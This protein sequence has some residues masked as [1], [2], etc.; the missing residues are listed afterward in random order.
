MNKNTVLLTVFSVVMLALIVL[1]S[2]LVVN[3][4]HYNLFLLVFA[5]ALACMAGAGLHLG[6]LLGIVSS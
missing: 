6:K 3:G 1:G 5:G 4:A 2:V